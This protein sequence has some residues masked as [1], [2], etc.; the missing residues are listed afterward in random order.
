MQ[1]FKNSKVSNSENVG[2][3]Q[4]DRSCEEDK[5]ISWHPAIQEEGGRA[6]QAYEY[7][8]TSWSEGEYLDANTSFERHLKQDDILAEFLVRWPESRSND[9][10]LAGGSIYRRN[11]RP[12]IRGGSVPCEFEK[13]CFLQLNFSL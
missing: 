1:V 12:S 7:K 8:F 4:S 11:H 3:D 13:I 2:Y 6:G 10:P 5:M 9:V